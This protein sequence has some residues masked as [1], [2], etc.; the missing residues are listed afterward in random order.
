M[1]LSIENKPSEKVALIDDSYCTLTYGDLKRFSEEFK[2]K[3][4]KRSVIFIMCSNAIGAVAGF[5]SCIENKIVPLLIDKDID[6]ILLDKLVDIYRPQYFWAPLSMRSKFHKEKDIWDV[7]EY[8]LLATDYPKYE[9]G[10]ELSLLLT[11]S[12][13][14]GSPKLV[15]HSYK[16]LEYS[17]KTVASFFGFL[18]TDNGMADL[19]MQYT[20]GLSVI[21]SHLYAGAKVTLTNHSLMNPEFW[22]RFQKEKITDFTGVPFSYE[23]FDRL[24]FFRK[25]MP[26]LRIL[27]EGGGRLS[28]QL[29]HKIAEYANTYGKQFFAT[30]GTTE[31]TARLSYLAPESALEK[32]GSIGKAIP[33]GELF[34]CDG[35]KNRIERIVAEGELGYAGEN[36]TMGYAYCRADLL[37]GDDRKGVYITGDIAKRDEDGCYYIIGRNARFLK[38]YG[39]RI[40][41]DQCERLIRDEFNIDCACTGN[42]KLMRIYI[43]ENESKHRI[44]D[45]ISE[46]THLFRNIF[47]VNYIPQ[48]P[49]SSTGKIL[50]KELEER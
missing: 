31:T 40:S 10:K 38:L 2:E 36:V 48:I 45:F 30:F 41:L 28:D 22:D 11:T 21:C 14:T 4:G 27:A 46:K 16:N 5:Y 8:C 15:R 32:I 43:S 26:D 49:R 35:N 29:Y 44:V 1:F 13:S 39:L 24:G 3:L 42:D 18:P 37:K 50:Y 19:P 25:N 9:I 7:L 23:V 34:L 12:G 33:G 47:K 20:M 6:Q 17:Y